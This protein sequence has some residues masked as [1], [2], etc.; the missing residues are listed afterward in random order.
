MNY[1]STRHAD[2][3]SCRNIKL[4]ILHQKHKPKSR[5]G[6]IKYFSHLD[7]YTHMGISTKA[8]NTGCSL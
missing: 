3:Y 8:E 1:G 7:D 6:V 5:I 4:K 2:F